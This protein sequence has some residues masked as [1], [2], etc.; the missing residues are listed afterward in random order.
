MQ[1]NTDQE[2]GSDDISSI[3]DINVTPFIDVMLVLLIIFM[4]T[5]PLMMGGVKINLP[6]TSGIPMARPEKPLII[7]LDANSKVYVDKDLVSDDQKTETFKRLALESE[8]GEVF[9]KGDGEVKYAKMM[10]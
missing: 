9:V 4:V 10:E 8:T 3:S 1:V 7:S 2:N 6:K 5:A